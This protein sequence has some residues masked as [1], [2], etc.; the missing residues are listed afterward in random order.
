ME[1]GAAEVCIT[2]HLTSE[3]NTRLGSMTARCTGTGKATAAYTSRRVAAAFDIYEALMRAVAQEADAAGPVSKLAAEGLLGG[4]EPSAAE[5]E[6]WF[7]S[8]MRRAPPSALSCFIFVKCNV[9][10]QP[11]HCVQHLS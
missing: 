1:A 7:Y 5:E 2:V 10:S 3:T 11:S 4:E 6:W 9:V 8:R